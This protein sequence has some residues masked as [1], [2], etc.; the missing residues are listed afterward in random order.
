M[1]VRSKDLYSIPNSNLYFIQFK[2]PLHFKHLRFISTKSHRQ[3]KC[4]LA[5]RKLYAFFAPIRH[6]MSLNFFYP[7]GF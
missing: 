3:P 2:L 4:Y 7:S 6:V 5:L 1:F